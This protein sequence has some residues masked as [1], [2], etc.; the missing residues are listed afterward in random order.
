[1]SGREDVWIC[2]WDEMGGWVDG[3]MGRGWREMDPEVA[4]EVVSMG[5]W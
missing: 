3:W 1:M 2:E 5:A 4:N